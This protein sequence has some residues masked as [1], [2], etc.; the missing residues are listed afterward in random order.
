MLPHPAISP[1]D[2]RFEQTRIEDGL[3]TRFTSNANRKYYTSFEYLRGKTR[4]AKGFIG[5]K[6][7]NSYKDVYLP[8][9]TG[10]DGDDVDILADAFQGDADFIDGVGSFPAIGDPGFNLYNSR[11]ADYASDIPTHGFRL[12]TG[13]NDADGSGLMLDFWIN[14]EGTSNFNAARA[15]T[16]RGN[17]GNPDTA[18]IAGRGISEQGLLDEVLNSPEGFLV[19]LDQADSLEVLS[20]N[21]LNLAAIPVDDGSLRLLSDGTYLGG[22]AIPYDLNFRLKNRTES[23]GAALDF[24]STR[25]VRKKFFKANVVFG[26]RYVYINESFRFDGEDSGLAYDSNDDDEILF[27]RAKIH[28][29]PNFA[30]DD[31]NFIV[32]DA[33]FIEPVDTTGTGGGGGGA[34]SGRAVRLDLVAAAAGR[35]HPGRYTAFLEHRLTTHLTGPEVGMN[36][37]LGGNKFRINGMTKVGVMANF[38]RLQLKGNNIGDANNIGDEIDLELLDDPDTATEAGV[39]DSPLISPTPD[40]PNPNA[41]ASSARTT[42]VSPLLEQKIQAEFPIFRYIPMFSRRDRLQ[43]ATFTAGWSVIWIGEVARP[44]QSILWKA[45]PREGLFP[46]I[47]ID[48]ADWWTMNWSC[49]I[50]IPF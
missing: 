25:S 15:L 21:L 30:D 34:G 5:H 31:G 3:W 48:R 44:S 49:G 22:T 8:I 41:F 35:E 19:D 27:S 17:V 36:Y 16:F 20:R 50:T 32:D 13:F 42:H 11:Y 4:H 43:D 2:N 10:E 14:L 23:M 28:S 1:F 33:I 40:N 18:G 24:I 45:N 29:L 37:S 26:G 7:A 47:K 39:A 38:E 12:V 46:S 6:R 9:L